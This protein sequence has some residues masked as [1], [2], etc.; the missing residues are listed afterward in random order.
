VR[1]RT[2]EIDRAVDELCELSDIELELEP[3]VIVDP[4]L[5][6]E[7]RRVPRASRRMKTVRGTPPPIRLPAVLLETDGIPIFVEEDDN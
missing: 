4:T 6:A 2:S 3:S 1:F 7:M 5:W